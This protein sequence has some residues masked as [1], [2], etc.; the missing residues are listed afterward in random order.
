MLFNRKAEISFENINIQPIKDLRIIFEIDK[1]DGVQ[2]NHATI[3][4]YNL[5]PINRAQIAKPHPIGFPLFEPIVKVFLKVGYENDIIQIIAG[6][7]LSAIN[8]K[9]GVDW[10]TTLEVWSGIKSITNGISNFSFGKPTKAKTIIDRLLQSLQIDFRYTDDAVDLL[11]NLKVSDFTSSGLTFR[12]V[13]IFLNRYGASFTIEEDNQGLVYID[14]RPRNPEEGRNSQNTFSP[15]NGL[16][17]SPEITRT[18]IIFRALLRPRIRLIERI[19]VS[20]KTL[21]GT[22]RAGSEADYHVTSV[23][24]KG[25]TRGEDWFTEIEGSY[26]NLIVGD[27]L[28]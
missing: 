14:D 2:L 23:K 15:T 3:K 6:E 16:V 21:V 10:I 19:F 27:Y 28:G 1:D 4:I 24:H 11:E 7:L 13:S 22:L 25:D 12:Q 26:S 8:Q 18:G 9:D 17:G 20:S 5:S